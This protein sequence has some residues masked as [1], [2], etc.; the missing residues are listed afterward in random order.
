ML[1]GTYKKLLNMMPE[2]VFVFDDKLR[3]SFTNA[4]FRRSFA[5]VSKKKMTL[6]ETL[7]C[8]ETGKCGENPACAYCTFYKTMRAAVAQNAE[9]T[10][11][12]QTTVQKNGRLDTN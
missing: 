4:A 1:D 3:V 6:A 5:G 9:K 7:G 2:G 10:E 12:M 11:T 8:Q